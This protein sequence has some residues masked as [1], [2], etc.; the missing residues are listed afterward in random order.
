MRRSALY[1]SILKGQNGFFKTETVAS[2]R[3][4]LKKKLALLL[5]QDILNSDKVAVLYQ[6]FPS[7]PIQ[8]DQFLHGYERV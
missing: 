3:L 7:R 4:Q 5:A 8:S 1:R 2:A 6:S